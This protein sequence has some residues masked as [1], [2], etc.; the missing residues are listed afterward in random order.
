MISVAWSYKVIRTKNRFYALDFKKKKNSTAD[1]HHGRH[2]EHVTVVQ[3]G[4]VV[5]RDVREIVQIVRVLTRAVY[6]SDLVLAHHS[7][8][9]GVHETHPPVRYHEHHFGQGPLRAAGHGVFEF[10]YGL[11]GRFR[12]PGFFYLGGTQILK[13]I[14]DRVSFHINTVREFSQI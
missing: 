2:A 14:T 7:A 12:A 4:V 9:H 8:R 13:R 6:V 3:A 11:L 5:L 10:L 1:S